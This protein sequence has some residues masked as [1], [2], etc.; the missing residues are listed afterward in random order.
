[1]VD[2]DARP[3]TKSLHSSIQGK[4]TKGKR[5]GGI[6]TVIAEN[7][8]LRVLPA[9][10]YGPLGVGWDSYV[11]TQLNLSFVNR[12]FFSP[13]LVTEVSPPSS[14]NCQFF[15]G[16]VPMFW[17]N[18]MK[19]CTSAHSPKMRSTFMLASTQRQLDWDYWYQLPMTIFVDSFISWWTSIVTADRKQL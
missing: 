17:H 15:N 18:R 9:T 6:M 2:L 3:T 7:S 14:L 10:L 4:E 19:F 12:Q 16:A 5:E 1:M 11:A 8:H 13:K